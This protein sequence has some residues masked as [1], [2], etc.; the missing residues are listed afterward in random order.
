MKSLFLLLAVF[1]CFSARN[2]SAQQ[3]PQPGPSTSTNSSV[4]T[5]T[6]PGSQAAIP[7]STK[8]AKLRPGFLII[9]TVF[10]ERVLSLPGATL[11]IRCEEEQKYRWETVSNSRGEFAVRVPEGHSYEVLVRA[12]KYLEQNVKVRTDQGDIQQ[13]LS[14]R[15]QPLKSEKKGSGQ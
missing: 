8:A 7:C 4:G 6:K 3:S 15:L 10:D 2:I 11:R 1:S 5:Q 13:R 12:K 9:G 14:I